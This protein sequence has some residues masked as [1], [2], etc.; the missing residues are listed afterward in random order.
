[1]LDNIY[2]RCIVDQAHPR[3]MWAMEIDT[4]V[5]IFNFNLFTLKLFPEWYMNI[6]D[7]MLR[8]IFIA[9]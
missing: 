5:L 4:F 7:M 2:H 6:I 3:Y 8:Q 9:E 1:M